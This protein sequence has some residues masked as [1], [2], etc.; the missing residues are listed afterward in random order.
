MSL[1]IVGIFFKKFYEILFENHI[2]YEKV[3][4][5]KIIIIFYTCSQEVLGGLTNGGAISEGACNWNR[6]GTSKQAVA[7]LIKIRFAFTGFKLISFI[8]S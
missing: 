3:I 7:V 1:Q 8:T 4:S 6:K 5:I 2:L